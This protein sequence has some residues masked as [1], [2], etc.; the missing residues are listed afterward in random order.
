MTVLDAF[1]QVKA[2]PE[3]PG[4][5]RE[6]LKRMGPMSKGELITL[7]TISGA[8]VLWMFGDAIGCPAVLAAMLALATLLCTG[9]FADCRR[10]QIRPMTLLRAKLP[11]CSE[12]KCVVIAM[13]AQHHNL[14]HPCAVGNLW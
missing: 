10:D 5:A 12:G 3:A 2:T 1:Q 14:E 11:C 7:A 6:N 4:L 9:R 8:V 13:C